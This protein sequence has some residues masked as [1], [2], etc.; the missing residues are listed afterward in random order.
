MQNTENE[1]LSSLKGD[2][3]S[4]LNAEEK[5]CV[6]SPTQANKHNAD[7]K[8][9]TNLAAEW[10]TKKTKIISSKGSVIKNMPPPPHAYLIKDIYQKKRQEAE[11]RRAEE[12]RKMREFHSRPAPSFNNHPCIRKSKPVHAITMPITP[13]VL[14]KSREAEEKRKKRVSFYVFY[15]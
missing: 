2:E 15:K 1:P 5:R 12:E 13:N 6:K 4:D 3:T 9:T 7:S 11:Q 8:R 10:S 14:K